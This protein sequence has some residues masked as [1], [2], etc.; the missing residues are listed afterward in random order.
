MK[1]RIRVTTIVEEKPLILFEG[2][3]NLKGNII[4]YFENDTLALTTIEIRDNGLI[5]NRHASDIKTELYLLKNEA[6]GQ[7][8]TSEG[9]LPFGDIKI[10]SYEKQSSYT[11]LTYQ[12]EDVVTIRIDQLGE[13]KCLQEDL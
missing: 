12:I 2:V 6:K 5:I 7:V 13:K 11:K 10:L 4:S 1:K 8:T 9:V 3:A